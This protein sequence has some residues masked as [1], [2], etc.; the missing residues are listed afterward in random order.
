[1][2]KGNVLSEITDIE[3]SELLFLEGQSGLVQLANHI[4]AV[5]NKE[6]C[7]VNKKTKKH[8]YL[9]LFALIFTRVVN[10]R[11]VAQDTELK[12]IFTGLS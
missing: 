8:V 10:R 7:N 5:N 12:Q 4:Q 6:A 1:M 3:L 9:L 11:A 2:E